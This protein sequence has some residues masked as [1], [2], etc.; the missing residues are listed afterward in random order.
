MVYASSYMS[1]I[2]LWWDERSEKTKNMKYRVYVD[3]KSCIYTDK[4]YFNFKNLESG[5]EFSFEVQ[6]VDENRNVIG[7]VEKLKV[8]TRKKREIIDITK[9]PYNAVG[10]AKTDNT[11]IIKKA[12]AD[13]IEGKQLYFPMGVYICEEIEFTGDIDVHFDVGAILCSKERERAL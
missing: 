13:L 4:V 6:L 10:D 11:S 9:P 8:N 2:R 7:K 12:M 3:G 5:K 1:E